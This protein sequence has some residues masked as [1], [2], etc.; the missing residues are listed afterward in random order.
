MKCNKFKLS[1]LFL[2]FTFAGVAQQP[3]DF[4]QKLSLDKGWLFH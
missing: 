4:Y 2:F 3:G 1:V